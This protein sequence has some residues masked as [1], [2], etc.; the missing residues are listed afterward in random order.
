MR[1]YILIIAI[2][3]VFT[4]M[5]NP[6]SLALHEEP[7]ELPVQEGVIGSVTLDIDDDLFVLRSRSLVG[8]AVQN[9]WG[10]DLG[11]I[12]D[13][14][15]DMDE[16]HIVYAILSFGGFLGLGSELFAVPWEALIPRPIEGIF[17]LNVTREKLQAASGFS[18]EEWPIPGDR[19]W[20]I[21]IYDS[22]GFPPPWGL[23][24][25]YWMGMDTQYG[26]LYNPDSTVTFQGNVV[27]VERFVP[28]GEI[29]ETVQL[30]I[31]H[32]DEPTLVHLGPLWFIHYKD[33]D[34]HEGNMARITG[35]RVELNGTAIVVVNEIESEGHSLSLRNE[36]GFPLWS[37]VLQQV[38]ELLAEETNVIEIQ[39]ILYIPDSIEIS[40]GET[41][42]W[43]NLGPSMHTVTSGNM[44][45]DEAGELFDSQTLIPGQVFSYTFEEAGEY[46]YF[47][48]Y[49]PHMTG[50]VIVAE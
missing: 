18:R 39:E 20:G 26:R 12:E 9:P 47:C 5:V 33:F 42:Y 50:I 19:E 41:V 22:Y 2:A 25:G 13:L 49:H 11:T 6:V 35:S 27:R 30:V 15:I 37:P 3:M 24:A 44:A 31:E 38:E 45:L 1:M 23:E 40:Q 8:S 32:D 28:T 7:E 10:E 46:T 14:V 4:V 17:V 34:I 29:M 43:V 36:A 21:G 48:R 16:G